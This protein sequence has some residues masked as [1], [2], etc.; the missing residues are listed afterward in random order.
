MKFAL[1]SPFARIVSYLLLGLLTV[2][3]IAPVI[4]LAYSVFKTSTQIF[5]SP[6]GLPTSLDFSNLRSAWQDAHFDVLYV[7]SLEITI[8]SVIG[9][10]IF[11][12][13]AAYAFAR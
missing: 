11:E 8:V 10:L 13:A 5:Q 7:N 2:I 9:I 12:G 6:F 1:F 3:V 4:W